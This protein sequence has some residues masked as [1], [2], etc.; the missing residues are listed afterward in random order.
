VRGVMR[1]SGEKAFQVEEYMPWAE[2]LMAGKQD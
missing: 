2:V 1:S